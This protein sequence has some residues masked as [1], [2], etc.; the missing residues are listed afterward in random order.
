MWIGGSRV[1]ILNDEK[2]V[3]MLRHHQDDKDIWLVPGGAIESNENSVEAAVREVK[4]ETGL[5][6]AIERL[7]W[8]V[9]EVSEKRGQRFV[10]FFLARITGGELNLGEDPE[11]I[12][13]GQVMCEIRF[14]S[15]DEMQNLSVLYPE[16]LKDELWTFLDQGT[17][18]ENIYKIRK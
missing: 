14:V 2:Q 3:L 7:I 18:A 15:K 10:N 12:E 16:Y 4:E 5:D 17:S 8:H 9:E 6:V 13:E 11:R 1:V